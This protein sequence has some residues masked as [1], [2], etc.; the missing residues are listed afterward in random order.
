METFESKIFWSLFF[1]I[2]FIHKLF[3]FYSFFQSEIFTSTQTKRNLKRMSHIKHLLIV[4]I[5]IIHYIMCSMNIFNY[6][7]FFCS[8]FSFI[9]ISLSHVFTLQNVNKIKQKNILLIRL[10]TSFNKSSQEKNKV[11]NRKKKW[12]NKLNNFFFFSEII[13]KAITRNRQ[14][15]E[16]KTKQKIKNSFHL[17]STRYE[18]TLNNVF[19]RGIQATSP[20]NI[21]SVLSS[22]MFGAQPRE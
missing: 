15:I 12:N 3:F 19:I 2:L 13:L 5:F 6:I 7:F 9:F 11:E 18:F 21:L 14:N 10:K 4:L 17:N 22:V 16:I 8:L 20:L 1:F